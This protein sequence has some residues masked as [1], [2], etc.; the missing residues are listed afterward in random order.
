MTSFL[1]MLTDFL[2]MSIVPSWNMLEVHGAIFCQTMPG[3][4][5]IYM[6]MWPR[7]GL[8]EYSRTT[9]PDH[10]CF[11]GKYVYFNSSS[12]ELSRISGF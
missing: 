9:D 6:Y 4:A 1:D 7:L 8:T 12:A 2:D 3:L 5:A 10:R 11:N